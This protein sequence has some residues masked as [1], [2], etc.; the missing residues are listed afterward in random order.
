MTG[1]DFA[2]TIAKPTKRERADDKESPRRQPRYH[3]RLWDDDDH[4][5]AYVIRMLRELFG[6]SLQQAEELTEGVDRQGSAICLTTTKEH[7]ELKRDQIHAYGRDH[8]NPT[9]AG[10]MSCSIEPEA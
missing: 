1:T 9:C 3:V 2:D 6:H 8:R 10:S 4:S 7:A 5:F